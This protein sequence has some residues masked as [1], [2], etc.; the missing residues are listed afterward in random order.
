MSCLVLRSSQNLIVL[1]V[2][3]CPAPA[4]TSHT[5]LTGLKHQSIITS[6]LWKSRMGLTEL[7][8]GLEGDSG[9][10]LSPIQEPDEFLGYGPSL[11]RQHCAASNLGLALLP[12][13]VSLVHILRAL[14]LPW[15]HLHH[16]DH[17]H[18]SW[19]ADAVT[20]L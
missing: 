2:D 1:T 11:P 5:H 13:S 9:M 17:L 18:I 15:A 4:I 14:W 8:E 7:A 20:L 3:E 19:P 16:H 10:L 6:G 12:C